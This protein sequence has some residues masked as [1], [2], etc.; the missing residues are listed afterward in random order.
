MKN[1]WIGYRREKD[2]LRTEIWSLLKQQGAS[3][4]DP[5]GHIPNFVGAQLAAEKLAS[6]PIWQQ[7]KTIKCNPD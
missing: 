4:G 1:D 5:F 3:N 7:A 2:K 6:L